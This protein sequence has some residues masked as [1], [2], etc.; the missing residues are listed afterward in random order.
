VEHSEGQTLRA[1]DERIASAF[2][3]RIAM[4]LEVPPTE[5]RTLFEILRMHGVEGAYIAASLG[6]LSDVYADSHMSQS[7]DEI[8]ENITLLLK[9]LIAGR[10]AQD[11]GDFIGLGHPYAMGLV[12]GVLLAGQ[13]VYKS[14]ARRQILQLLANPVGEA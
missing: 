8:A 2:F 4:M 9:S 1:I 3:R 11:H 12:C 13:Y 5:R 14:N 10:L 7:T 6:E